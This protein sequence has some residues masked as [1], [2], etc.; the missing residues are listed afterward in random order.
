[1][2]A[3]QRKIGRAVVRKAAWCQSV[4]GDDDHERGAENGWNLKWREWFARRT[5]AKRV[6]PPATKARRR[7]RCGGSVPPQVGPRGVMART[8]AIFRGPRCSRVGQAVI[9]RC[10][11][12]HGSG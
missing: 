4:N 12:L 5:S 8:T 9:C 11:V 1:V 6:K 7:A 3:K 2:P 10:G